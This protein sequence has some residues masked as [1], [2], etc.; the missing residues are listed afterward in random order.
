MLN[1]QWRLFSQLSLD[2]LYAILA[3]RTN[4]FIVEQQCPYMDADGNDQNALHLLGIADQTLVAYL[5]VFLPT[6]DNAAIV[7]GRVV[8][9][10]TARKLGYGKQL[11]QFFLNYCDSEFPGVM[12]KCSAQCY[13]QRFYESFGFVAYGDPYEEDEISHIA[14]KR[15]K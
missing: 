13:L 4:V 1:F 14:M 10:P 3:L 2:Q 11:M 15:V 5:R 9:A 12:I 6:E 7:F 8:T